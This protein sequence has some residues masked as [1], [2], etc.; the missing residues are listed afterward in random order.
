VAT[1]EA[2]GLQLDAVGDARATPFG[3]SPARQSEA[4][5]IA[6]ERPPIRKTTDIRSVVVL[7]VE[8]ATKSISSAL[9]RRI[10]RIDHYESQL[11]LR[12]KLGDGVKKVAKRGW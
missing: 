7:S 9:G 10:G 5:K 12:G 1:Q 2:K 11:L 4:I 6:A 3:V 8:G